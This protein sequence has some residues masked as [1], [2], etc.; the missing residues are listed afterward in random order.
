MQHV[1]IWNFNFMG[2]K[3]YTIWAVA[4]FLRSDCAAELYDL[5]LYA[6]N[7]GIAIAAKIP[8]IAITIINS[9]SVKPL[10]S[11]VNLVMCLPPWLNVCVNIKM[12]PTPTPQTDFS[13][14]H[15]RVMR[16]Y[17]QGLCHCTAIPAKDKLRIISTT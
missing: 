8:M 17:I 6:E 11:L 5:V 12:L 13:T 9:I 2:F 7:C 15:K 1:W 10:S 4:I 14:K 3:H 16:I